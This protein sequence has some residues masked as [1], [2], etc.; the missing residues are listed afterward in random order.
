MLRSDTPSYYARSPFIIA[1]YGLVD[2]PPSIPGFPKDFPQQTAKAMALEF[3]EVS[4]Q[5]CHA[6]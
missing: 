1:G 4:A 2:C 5:Q 6:L 3:M